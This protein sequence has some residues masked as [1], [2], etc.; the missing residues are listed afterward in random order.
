MNTAAVPTLKDFVAELGE[1]KHRVAN[2]VVRWHSLRNPEQQECISFEV[3][4]WAT[5]LV[6]NESDPE[7][8]LLE[9]Y[10]PCGRDSTKAKTTEGSDRAAKLRATLA[11]FCD[12]NGLRLRPGKIEVY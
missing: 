11:E 8:Y 4:A 9:C 2:R 7:A 1:E 12:D 6:G 10:M 5:A 3:G